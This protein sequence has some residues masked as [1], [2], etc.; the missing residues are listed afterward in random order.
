[1]IWWFIVTELGRM[2][3]R[4]QKGPKLTIE[5]IEQLVKCFQS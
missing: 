5:T 4:E 1:M 2:I 3:L